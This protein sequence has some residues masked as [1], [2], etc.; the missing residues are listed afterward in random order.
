MRK[1]I[2]LL[3]LVFIAV[4]TGFAA[5]RSFKQA[6]AIAMRKAA[7]LGIVNP[8]ASFSKQSPGGSE[9]AE[10]KAYYM[11]DNG[12]DRG[13][14]IVSGDDRLQEVI[15]YSTRGSLSEGTMP[16]QLKSLL[17]AF[18]KEYDKL[19]GDDKMM[20]CATAER[21]ALAQ[22]FLSANVN[23][24]PLLGDIQWGQNLK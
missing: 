18:E 12:G 17:D 9:D 3:L 5:P 2:L 6:R 24:D 23:V 15:G 19:V 21:K 13:F 1:N 20:E 22:S 14:V 4:Q 16:I 8:N 11:F 10:G 7:S